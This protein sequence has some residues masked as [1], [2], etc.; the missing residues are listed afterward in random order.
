MK[1]LALDW[2]HSEVIWGSEETNP[3][4]YVSWGRGQVIK[5]NIWVKPCGCQGHWNVLRRHS[6]LCVLSQNHDFDVIMRKAS[7]KPR[8]RDI[9]QNSCPASSW[10][11]RHEKESQRA[12]T[13]QSGEGELMTECH[14]GS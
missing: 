9:L 8:R 4:L 13:T 7:H 11:P 2:E 1:D 12:V 3:G 5:V 6:A 14:V 10:L